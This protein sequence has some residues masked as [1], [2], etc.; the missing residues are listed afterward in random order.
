MSVRK[1]LGLLLCNVLWSASYSISKSRMQLLY[2][3]EIAFLRYFAAALPL[4]GY[5]AFARPSKQ[6]SRSW[7]SQWV[8]EI[9]LFDLRLVAIGLLTFFV[10]PLTQMEG[11]SRTRAMDGSLMIAIEP[12]VTIMAACFMLR[13]RLRPIQV[14]ALWLAFVGALVVTDV[15]WRKLF[16]FE[17]NRLVG[18]AIFMVTMAS[19]AA[20]STIA[21]P[22]LGRRSPLIILTI[23]LCVGVAAMSAYNMIF[24]DPARVGGLAPLLRQGTWLDWLAIAYLGIGCTIFGY[25]YWM[26]VLEDTP[27]SM[28][29]L[30]LY[31]QP[32]LGLLWGSLLLGESITSSTSAGAAIILVA[33]W[34][35]SR[36]PRR[37]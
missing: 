24:I 2:P 30:T 29:A 5:C 32:V 11:L 23:S 13:E 22:V 9:D 4:L 7:L 37:D 10:S 25:L 28:M 8:R 18:N 21:K 12:L 17:D 31:A 16:A 35:G 34:L 20:Y 36:P 26:V 1:L 19:E 33:V 3:S 6:E 14:G 27:L 15:T